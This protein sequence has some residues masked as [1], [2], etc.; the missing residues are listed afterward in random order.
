VNLLEKN[1]VIVTRQNKVTNSFIHY[2]SWWA[3]N[4]CFEFWWDI[5]EIEKVKETMW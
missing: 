1:V 5:I 3:N 4:Y 2:L